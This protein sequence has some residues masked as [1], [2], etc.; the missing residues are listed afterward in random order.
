[1]NKGERSTGKEF[2]NLARKLILAD[3]LVLRP[4][5]GRNSPTFRSEAFGRPED[6]MLPTRGEAMAG[7]YGGKAVP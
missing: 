2:E 6:G 5:Q 4:R 1:M 7:F 3:K